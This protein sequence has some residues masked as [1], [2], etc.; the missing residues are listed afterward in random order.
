M[1]L[2]EL[3]R[4]RT[5][6]LEVLIEKLTTDSKTKELIMEPVNMIRDKEN[7]SA[8]LAN[9]IH[10]VA[11]DM[12]RDL[13]RHLIERSTKRGSHKKIQEAIER[14]KEKQRIY[15]DFLRTSSLRF[16]NKGKA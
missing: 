15:F 16:K 6:T 5:E 7:C 10:F 3:A 13:A 2:R 14:E 1:R 4:V 11:F 9:F 12:P 8:K